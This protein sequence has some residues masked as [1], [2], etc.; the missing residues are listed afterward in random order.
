MI[1][2][3]LRAKH[4]GLPCYLWVNRDTYK[5]GKL[6]TVR[7]D[8]DIMKDQEKIREKA[9]VYLY[10]RPVDRLLVMNNIS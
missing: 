5:Y 2:A 9:A 8:L 4:N 1:V 3:E 7:V 10:G 6:W